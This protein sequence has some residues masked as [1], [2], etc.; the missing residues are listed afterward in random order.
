MCAPL[1]HRWCVCTLVWARP[2]AV[3]VDVYV[4][5]QINASSVCL[6]STA[7]S[8]TRARGRARV[9]VWLDTVCVSPL[10]VSISGYVSLCLSC[11][12]VE[13][14]GKFRRGGGPGS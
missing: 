5:A 6:P 3:G 4:R 9:R 11:D 7:A 8:G 12:K 14:V 13:A 1:S 2:A 10:G